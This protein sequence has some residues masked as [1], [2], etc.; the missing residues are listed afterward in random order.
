MALHFPP[1]QA[2]DFATDTVIFPAI[3]DNGIVQCRIERSVF[4]KHFSIDGSMHG[5]DLVGIF[6][7]NRTAILAKARGLIE[8]RRLELNGSLLLRASDFDAQQEC[9]APAENTGTETP[10]Q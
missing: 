7:T 9:E 1:Q 4:E 10:Q 8:S 6:L 3:G 2:Y 5:E